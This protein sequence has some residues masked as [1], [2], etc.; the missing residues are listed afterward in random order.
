MQTVASI[1]MRSVG[2]LLLT[3]PVV[4][5]EVMVP[6]ATFETPLWPSCQRGARATRHSGGI[7]M[8]V[9]KEGMCRSFVL[10]AKNAYEAFTVVQQLNQRHAEMKGVVS[11]TSD[12]CQFKTCHIEQLSGLLYFRLECNTGDAAGHNMVTKAADALIQW[13]LTEYPALAYVT[14]SGNFCT[15]KKVSAV[16]GILGRGK[17]VIAETLLS[18]SICKSYLKTTP[19]QLVETHIKK[20][21][22]GSI[23]AGSI[24]SANAHIANMLLAFYLAT[25]QDAAN[26]VEGSQGIVHAE[27]RG[28]NCYFSVNVPN[29]IVGTVGNGKAQSFVQANLQ[30]LDCL[31]P[32]EVGVNS[33]RLAAIAGAVILCG[34]LSLLAAQTTQG[35]LM[36]S[37]Q[38][39]ERGNTNQENHPKC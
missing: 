32:R 16:N 31:T 23:I 14:I 25:G 12:Y 36:R 37:H 35:E 13:C 38:R 10:E 15:D 27:M 2:P 3:G 22:L 18:P 20:N 19:E 7:N 4:Q 5:G 21:L 17:S 30:Q 9:L 1:P 28:E 6:L 11:K 8:I 26:I 29:I 33:R 24:R 34:E 39:L